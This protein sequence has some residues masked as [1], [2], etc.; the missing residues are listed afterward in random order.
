M[1]GTAVGVPT[2]YKIYDFPPPLNATYY[3]PT[4]VYSFGV[5]PH[6]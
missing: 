3:A 2:Q 4:E 6:W 5:D 1:N